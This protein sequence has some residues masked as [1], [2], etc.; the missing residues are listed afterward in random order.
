MGGSI[1][2]EREKVNTAVMNALAKPL[3]TS[4]TFLSPLHA[5]TSAVF[6]KN[7]KLEFITAA[8][9]CWVLKIVQIFFFF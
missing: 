2:P 8:N 3:S 4:Y 9:S 5:K 6:G 1:I 7:W